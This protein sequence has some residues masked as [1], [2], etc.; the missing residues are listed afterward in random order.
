MHRDIKPENILFSTNDDSKE[1]KLIDFGLSDYL[2]CI[3]HKG[4]CLIGSLAYLSPE[5]LNLKRYDKKH[6][7]WSLGVILYILLSGIPPFHGNDKQI[8]SMIINCQ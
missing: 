5:S 2:Y 8:K 4:D 3:E 7:V 6:D 1:I